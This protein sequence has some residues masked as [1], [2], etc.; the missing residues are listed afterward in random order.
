MSKLCNILRAALLL[1]AVGTF[2]P[3]NAEGTSAPSWSVAP[4]PGWTEPME[5]PAP[6]P[7]PRGS[8]VRLL[9]FD[10]QVRV[11]DGKPVRYTH[12]AY[13]PQT[14]AAVEQ[15]AEIKIL[16]NPD[17]QTLA[18]H[19]LRVIRGGV[20]RDAL[21]ATP[22]RM[23]QRE[24]ELER[25]MYDGTTT[26]FLLLSDVRAGD[27]IEY[28]Y[29]ING[30]NPVFGD[31]FAA[32]YDLGFSETVGRVRVR[33]QFPRTRSIQY[34]VYGTSARPLETRSGNDRVLTWDLRD[35]VA[36][37]DEGDYPRGYIPQPWVQFSEYASW[38]EV[39]QWAQTL[40]ALPVATGELKAQARSLG[41]GGPRADASHRTLRFVQEEVRYFGIELGQSSHRPSPPQETLARRYGDCKDKTV[42]LASLLREQ[43]AQAWP[44]LVSYG[45]GRYV[46]DYLPSPL[47]FDH[48][49]TAADID[50]RSYYLDGTRR[51]QPAPLDLV[52]NADFGFALVVKPGTTALREVPSPRPWEMEIDE[53][54]QATDYTSPLTLTVVSRYQGERAEY[55]RAQ[56]ANAGAEEMQRQFSNFYSRLFPGAEALGE[57]AVDD[58]AESNT[59]TVRERYRI[60]DFWR[61]ERQGLR[62]EVYA[63]SLGELVQLPRTVTRKTPLYQ[64][65][66]VHARHRIRIEY[67]EEVGFE[68][69]APLMLNDAGLEY[70]RSFATQGRTLT[71]EHDYLSKRD[72]LEPAEV[73]DHVRVLRQIGD[74]LSYAAWFRPR[75]NTQRNRADDLTEQLL[76]RLD[77][78]NGAAP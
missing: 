60:P 14:D 65:H 39:V 46:A 17:Y 67:P 58:N 63:H 27:I 54:Y 69:K 13:S 11:G 5:L 43:G 41:G 57:F 49:I 25:K 33:L 16:F 76:R 62:F 20:A 64:V 75:T 22:V 7:A 35:T 26:A 47:L 72:R 50:G 31:K 28:A 4:S 61:E 10:S 37:V 77:D 38:A 52:T 53:L 66:A 71:I 32:G 1:A 24:S 73:R 15:A 18:L 44:A 40:Y 45:N 42:L 3:A 12:L 48:V 2:Q 8:S 30:E 68:A 9:L 23:L 70:R 56:H 74:E 36:V 78:K 59:L 34:R 55:A 29:S 6:A 21:P 51:F 19:A